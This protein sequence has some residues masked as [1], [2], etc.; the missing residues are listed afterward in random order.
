M[1]LFSVHNQVQVI[2]CAI[3]LNHDLKFPCRCFPSHFCFLN[4]MSIFLFVFFC[5]YFRYSLLFSSLWILQVPKLLYFCNLQCL[6]VLFFL[7]F[8]TCGVYLWHSTGETLFASS[9]SLFCGSHLWILP[10]SNL[11]RVQNIFQK[12]LPGCLSPWWDF[13]CR[14]WFQEVFL[15]FWDITFLLFLLF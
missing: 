5:W 11:R 1:T 7:L 10:L 14:I 9:N 15:F 4:L 13:C 12:G 2:A 3:S 8:L 6:R